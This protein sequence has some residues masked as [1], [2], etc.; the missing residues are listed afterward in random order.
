MNITS[1]A[2]KT[3]SR[4]V[5]IDRGDHLVAAAAK[6]S[7]PEVELVVVTDP[8]GIMVGVVSRVDVVSR[9]SKCTGCSCTEEV[10]AAMTR[11]VRSCRSED[12]LED[13]WSRMRAD[14][15]KNFPV[16]DGTGRPQG[17]A[18]ARDVLAHL[19]EER[20]YEEALLRDYVLGIGYR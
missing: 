8:E 6:L 15:L 17:V 3:S 18:A 5:R 7:D 11:D 13:V 19:L 10:S 12:R 16:V 4:L 9:I 14:G 20:D 1:L 2:E